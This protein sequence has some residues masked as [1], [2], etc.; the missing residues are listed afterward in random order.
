MKLAFAA[1]VFALLLACAV[2]AK[3]DNLVYVNAWEKTWTYTSGGPTGT[4]YNPG[5]VIF[6]TF[7]T[8]L[9]GPYPT[10]PNPQD[11]AYYGYALPFT[12]EASYNGPN[13]DQ[14]WAGRDLGSLA[15]YYR[16]RYESDG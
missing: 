15:P 2:T 8:G 14:V 5:A 11:F 4:L 10:D 1:F 6:W 7:G 13:N 16:Y 12:I 3:A 9:A